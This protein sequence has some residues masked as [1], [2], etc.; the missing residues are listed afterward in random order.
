MRRSSPQPLPPSINRLPAFGGWRVIVGSLA[1]LVA[2]LGLAACGAYSTVHI[3]GSPQP[4]GPGVTPTNGAQSTYAY[5]YSRIDYPLQVPI[6]STDTV[7][8]SLSPLSDILTV[9][10]T[11]GTGT[12]TFS[13]PIPLPTDLQDY[14]DI[15]ASVDT[16]QPS[17]SAPLAW[18][19]VSAPRQSLLI[20]AGAGVRAY[21][22]D[23]TFKWQV[24]AVSAGQNTTQIELTLYYVYL[25]GSEHDGTV[26]V[27]QSPIPVVAV[28]VSAI[29][30]SLP[31]LRLPIA[32]LTGLAGVF[33]FFRFL[34]GAY[35]TMKDA[36]D[37]GRDAAKV[38]RTV[39]RRAHGVPV[40]EGTGASVPG[41][42]R[43]ADRQSESSVAQTYG[44][45][46]NDRLFPPHGAE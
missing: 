37:T 18:Q 25:D 22:N 29:N 24:R 46:H 35:R 13:E 36:A 5:L 19:L 11:A 44:Q 8:L 27:S 10:P 41:G 39:Q 38:A 30:K 20:P 23:V 31:P 26:M 16:R 32:G 43:P 7:T 33:A 15:G 45:Q 12:T 4:T 2:A 17:G 40:G 6:N 42:A 3:T 28:N 9:A 14:Q 21:A 1:I 34:W